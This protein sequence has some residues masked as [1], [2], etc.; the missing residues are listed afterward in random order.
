M[1]TSLGL[2]TLSIPAMMGAI[3]KC[4][5]G[6]HCA[7][8]SHLMQRI[9]SGSRGRFPASFHVKSKLGPRPASYHIHLSPGPR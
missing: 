1:P 7:L 2:S 9:V 4:R 3:A 5:I 8:A 6:F